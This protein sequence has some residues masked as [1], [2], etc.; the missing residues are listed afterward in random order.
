MTEVTDVDPREIIALLAAELPPDVR[1]HVFVVGS[2]A[3]ACHHADLIRG[4]KVKTKDADLVVHPA[5]RASSAAVIARR[6]IREGWRHKDSTRAPG[7]A[8]APVGEL[9]FIRLYPPDH[10]RYFVEILVAPPGEGAGVAQLCVELDDGWYGLPTFEFLILT[11]VDRERSRDGLEYAHPSTMALANLLS[12][13][14]LGH[15]VMSTQVE[16]RDI[17][18]SSKD[19]G[20][21]LALARLASREET[22]GWSLRWQSALAACFPQRWQ[23]LARSAGDGL[24]ALLADDVR[25]DE[26]WHCCNAGLLA[27]MG[28]TQDQLRMIALQLLEDAIAPL[29]ASGASSPP[30]DPAS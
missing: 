20:R 30:L 9:P 14:V 22:E 8:P 28:V 2:L 12:H 10:D 24:R 6:L 18:R 17:H 15:H 3:G 5:S 29:E 11:T 16:Q 26:A 25:F 19:L 23:A 13:P 7:R 4:G 1:D 21:V 27:G